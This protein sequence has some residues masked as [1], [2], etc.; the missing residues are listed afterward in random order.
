EGRSHAVEEG[1]VEPHPADVERQ[2]ERGDA[3]EVLLIPLPELGRGHGIF[4]PAA[5]PWRATASWARRTCSASPRY[6]CRTGR[7]SAS[8][9][10][11]SGTP[12]GMFSPT[13]SS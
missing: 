3:A 6:S 1:V 8:S 9:S 10:Y 7:R 11:T 13:M 5:W 4:P 2:A 12:V